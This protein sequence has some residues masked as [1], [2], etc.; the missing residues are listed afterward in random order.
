MSDMYY[1]GGGGFAPAALVLPTALPILLWSSRVQRP[2]LWDS[3]YSVLA[4][5]SIVLNNW[6]T[7]SVGVAYRKSANSIRDYLLINLAYQN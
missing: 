1:W 3:L 5:F 2:T 6:G 7:P 4:G